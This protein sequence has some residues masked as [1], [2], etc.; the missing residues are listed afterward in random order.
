MIALCTNRPAHINSLDCDVPPLSATD[1]EDGDTALDRQIKTSFT[2]LGKL[3]Q[4]I[5]GVI[6]LPLANYERLQEQIT[7]CDQALQTGACEAQTIT[8]YSTAGASESTH[9]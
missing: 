2:E 9:M 7:L 8:I 5:E 6:S 3:C 4:I 1:V